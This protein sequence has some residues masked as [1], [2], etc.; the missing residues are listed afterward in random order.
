[1]ILWIK[2]MEIMLFA[3]TDRYLYVIYVNIECVECV[4]AINDAAV[5]VIFFEFLCILF[6]FV[7]FCVYVCRL[8]FSCVGNRQFSQIFC[9]SLLS[10]CVCVCVYVCPKWLLWMLWLLNEFPVARMRTLNCYVFAFFL[11]QL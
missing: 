4:H 1:M 6:S 10:A 7:H 2:W 11:I 8:L 5:E 3:S 9:F